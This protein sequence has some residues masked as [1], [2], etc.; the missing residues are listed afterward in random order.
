[1]LFTKEII[2]VT[3]SPTRNYLWKPRLFTEGDN[4][5]S[6]NLKLKRFPTLSIISLVV[7]VVVVVVVALLPP[8]NFTWSSDATW[9]WRIVIWTKAAIEK[10]PSAKMRMNFVQLKSMSKVV[11]RIARIPMKKFR[12]TK[13][14]PP[15]FCPM[16][17]TLLL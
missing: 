11:A 16:R 12:R 5:I 4:G 10:P 1:M 13:F 15:K 3:S 2:F 7:V 6:P 9:K 8:W 17:L 14:C